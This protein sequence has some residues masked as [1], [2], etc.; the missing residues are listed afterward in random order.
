MNERTFTCQTCGETGVG[1][2]VG[3]IHARDFG[4]F[5]KFSISKA[6]QR[7]FD[8]EDPKGQVDAL[9]HAITQSEV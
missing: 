5:V 7:K 8:W 9:C 3:A 4:H 2:G 1:A 6:R